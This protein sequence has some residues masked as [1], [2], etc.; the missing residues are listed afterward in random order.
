MSPEIIA[1]RPNPDPDW[2]IDSRD[3]PDTAEGA[4][5]IGAAM[6]TPGV[7][8]RPL[9]Y[10]AAGADLAV[11]FR[12][13]IAAGPVAL[14]TGLSEALVAAFDEGYGG[15]GVSARFPPQPQDH[16]AEALARA[17]KG[18][19]TIDNRPIEPD[20]TPALA[21]HRVLIAHAAQRKRLGP[22]ASNAA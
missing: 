20:Q 17:A 18:A 7:F 12:R 1:F 21:V 15:A 22:I 11:Y 8:I 3:F 13:G 5:L 10:G 14:R 9:A 2:V 19:E 16:V 6:A 4:R